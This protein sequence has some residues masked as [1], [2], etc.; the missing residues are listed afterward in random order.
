[1]LLPEA[2]GVGGRLDCSSACT[3]RLARPS[4]RTASRSRSASASPSYPE[5]ARDREAL[6]DVADAALYWAKNHGKNR[7][8]VY[9]P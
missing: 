3:A 6:C 8:C 9:S 7:S 2:L 4:S 5:H 1:M